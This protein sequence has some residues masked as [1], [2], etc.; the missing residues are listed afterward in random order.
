MME[1]SLSLA[2]GFEV[3]LVAHPKH[4]LPE[5]VRLNLVWALRSAQT[6]C[7]INLN[8]CAQALLVEYL[9]SWWGLWLGRPL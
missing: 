2:S 5:H 8:P 1:V 6:F 4:K 3:S 9:F 7:H